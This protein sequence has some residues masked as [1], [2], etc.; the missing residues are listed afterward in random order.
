MRSTESIHV[1]VENAYKVT[2]A[3]AFVPL[4]AGL[5]WK[6]ATTQ[7][8]LASILVGLLT[9]I[10]LEMVAPDAVVP[11]HFAGMLAALAAMVVGSLAPQALVASHARPHHL[12]MSK[13][14]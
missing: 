11:P 10:G 9:W 2:L 12:Q 1:M 8:A 5:Y 14:E 7:G 3:T 6:R 13:A 4:A